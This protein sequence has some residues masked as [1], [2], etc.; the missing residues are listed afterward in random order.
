MC[1]CLSVHGFDLACTLLPP[2]R[3]QARRRYISVGILGGTV[4][5]M[6]AALQ[7]LLHPPTSNPWVSVFCC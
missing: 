5:Y 7:G 3:P 4:V 1:A 6:T 2:K